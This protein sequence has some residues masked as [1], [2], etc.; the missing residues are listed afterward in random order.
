MHEH[1]NRSGSD[2][3]HTILK[4]LAGGD[5]RSLGRANEVVEGVLA[6][7]PDFRVLFQGLSLVDAVVRMRA[8]DA[9]EK[10]TRK[11]PELLLPYAKKL[12]SIAAGEEQIE[13]RWHMAL[14]LPRLRLSRGERDAAVDILHDYLKDSSSIVKTFAM[15]GLADFALR[16][17]GLLRRVLPMIEELTQIGT[18]AM[19]A[20][21]RKLLTALR[22]RQASGGRAKIPKAGRTPR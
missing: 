10:V 18:P 16:D 14:M 9:M 15:Q 20:R 4:K 5:R 8:A 3:I 7:P 1:A 11:R 22:R 12:L 17:S 13:V 2:S 21:G 6:R 19:R